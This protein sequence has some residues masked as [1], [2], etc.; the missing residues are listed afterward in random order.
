MGIK[1]KKCKLSNWPYVGACH[2]EWHHVIH[3]EHEDKMIRMKE[4]ERERRLRYRDYNRQKREEKRDRRS[5]GG[6]LWLS[7]DIPFNL[8]DVIV[9][10]IDYSL[11]HGGN[12][13]SDLSLI[14]QCNIN[15]VSYRK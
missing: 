6:A 3:C 8:T 12:F 11:P 10:T 7:S 1:Y 4:F 9:N 5:Q 14:A 13:C 2:R 15:S